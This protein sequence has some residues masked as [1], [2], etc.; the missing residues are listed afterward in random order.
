MRKSTVKSLIYC[1][2]LLLSLSLLS[3]CA[4]KTAGPTLDAPAPNALEDTNK[5]FQ[6][7]FFPGQPSYMMPKETFFAHFVLMK[8]AWS[9]LGTPYVLGG[10]TPSGFD[11][12]G[13]VQW[14]YKHVGVNLPRTAREQSSFGTPIKKKEELRVGDIVAFRHPRRG[15]HTGIYIGEGKFIHS[16]RTRSVVKINSLDDSYFR[17]TFLGARRIDLSGKEQLEM[18][19]ALGEVATKATPEKKTEVKAKTK[20]KTEKKRRVKNEKSRKSK[21]NG[22]SAARTT[23]SGKTTR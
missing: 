12:S 17:R 18:S 8:T 9:A 22:H 1:L 10:T 2:S 19:K 15:Y 20:S 5:Q 13:F 7:A 11:C 4:S 16:P 23:S 3:G 6:Q 21:T 14:T